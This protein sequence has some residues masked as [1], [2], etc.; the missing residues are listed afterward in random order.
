MLLVFILAYFFLLLKPHRHPHLLLVP[1]LQLSLRLQLSPLNLLEMVPLLVGQSLVFKRVLLGH[2]GK[3]GRHRRQKSSS[4]GRPS[5]HLLLL[6]LLHLKLNLL[7]MPPPRQLRLV[8]RLLVL[9]LKL[10]LPLERL[11]FPTLLRSLSVQLFLHH[12]ARQR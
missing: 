6:L 12:R 8:P 2:M 1:S 4:S 7:H 3:T 11:H 10:V 5:V 9:L